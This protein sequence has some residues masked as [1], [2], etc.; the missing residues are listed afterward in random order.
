VLVDY[1]GGL[2][3]ITL[4]ILFS[5]ATSIFLCESVIQV[6][7]DRSSWDHHLFGGIVSMVSGSRSVT[8]AAGSAGLATSSAVLSL[9]RQDI[10]RNVYYAR[11]A[12]VHQ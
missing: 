12:L 5:A 8:P 1:S 3:K 4:F 11:N 9:L 6:L 2:A 7:G 10:L